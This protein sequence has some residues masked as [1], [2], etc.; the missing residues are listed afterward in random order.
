MKK[1]TT[2]DMTVVVG[3]GNGGRAAIY[4]PGQIGEPEFVF[5]QWVDVYIAS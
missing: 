2:K 4:R 3:G 1:L 5:V